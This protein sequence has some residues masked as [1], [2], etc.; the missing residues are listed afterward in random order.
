MLAPESFKAK[1]DEHEARARVWTEAANLC[2]ALTN[3]LELAPDLVSEAAR[4][5]VEAAIK[6]I[7]DKADRFDPTQIAGTHVEA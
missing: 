4:G 6:A 7:H 5:H 1:A 3:A 2:R